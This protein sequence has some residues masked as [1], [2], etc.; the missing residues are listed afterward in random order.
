MFLNHK[1]PAFFVIILTA[2]TLAGCFDT[3]GQSPDPVIRDFGIAYI[4][5]PIIID[6]D[7]QT[8]PDDI[9][10]IL[11]FREGGDLYMRDRA[12]PSA[13]E[14]NITAPVTNGTGDVKD[15]A[16]SFDGNKLLF[17]MRLSD[18]ESDTWNIWEYD[19]REKRLR[20]IIESD[21]TAE[22]GHDTAPHYLPDGRIVFTSTRQR[23]T[24]AMLLDEGKPKFSGLDESRNEPAS[25][26]HVMNADGSAIQ[27]ISFN[28]SHDFNPTVLKS[29]EI[30]FSRWDHMGGKNEINLYRINPDGGTGLQLLYGAHS[31]TT[32]TEGTTI[33]FIRPQLM[34]DGRLLT[35]IRPFDAAVG[36]L[37][38]IDTAN[39]SDYDQPLPTAPSGT[40][41]TKATSQRI[42]LDGSLSTGGQFH[43][44][45]PLW[46]GSGRLLVS[47]S[48]CRLFLESGRL[49]PCNDDNIDNPGTTA[50]P[51]LYGIY[52]FDAEQNTM[53]P[54]IPPRE[55][56]IIS[57]AIALQPREI[58]PAITDASPLDNDLVTQNV[59]ILHIRS[60]YDF[61]GSFNDL[62]SGA[63]SIAELADPMQTSANQRPAR[64]L[65]LIKA[66]PIPE[67]TSSSSF[68]RSSRQKMREIIGYG[69]IEPDGSVMVKVPANIAFTISIVDKN[70]QRIG[71]RHPNWLQVKPGETIECHGCHDAGSNKPHGRPEAGNALNAGATTDN[72]AFP[73]TRPE[74]SARMGE[75]M[76][77]TRSRIS[78]ETDCAALTPSMDMIF[79]DNWTDPNLRSPDLSFSY[80]YTDL[81]TP[82][83]TATD[84]LTQWHSLC[85]VVI[86]YIQHIHPIWSTPRT[87]G[88]R[89]TTCSQSQCH[90]PVDDNNNPR[91]PAAQ[92]DLSTTAPS[93]QN[94]NHITT[95]RELF[96]TDN[97][98]IVVN[99]V[100]QDQ[101]IQETDENGRPL[102][103]TDE[104][105]DLVRDPDGNPIP[106]L[107][108][109]RAP[110]PVMSTSGARSFFERFDAPQINHSAYLSPAERRLISEWLDIGGQY[111]NN[112]FDIPSAD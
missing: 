43:S 74:L 41:Q 33:Q 2:S 66:V 65:R 82:L 30:V 57:D 31:H 1:Y 106:I 107:I 75:T 3:D 4:K 76:A 7:G 50:A 39:F 89:D 69:M 26:L 52:I 28:Q 25:V 16:V 111:Y 46:D 58:P 96:F 79:E 71:D 14:Q 93:D 62:G 11:N 109:V 108:T 103:E 86:N 104:N 77:Q 70:G 49:I 67:G 23:Q 51:P 45:S 37:V 87:T 17:A 19:T 27:Q 112:P 83:P 55:G 53:Q 22:M 40:T 5:R 10:E 47:W 44:A 73:N 42:L 110:S 92:L 24:G 9:R 35:T 90:S 95:Y 54:L 29:G 12:S 36:D 6:E 81:A 48:Q 100:L 64:F 21:N 91:V 13:D 80:R 60:V 97:A 32:G 88:T 98:Q 15:L 94:P 105:G 72:M 61:D 8:V 99:G 63:E 102:Y 101:R 18:Q 20:R 68:G 38:I 59:G 78:C 56:F 84:C 85:R 34:P